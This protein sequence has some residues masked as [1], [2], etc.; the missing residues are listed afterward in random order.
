MTR[1]AKTHAGRKLH[2]PNGIWTY[3]IG[4]GSVNIRDPNGF[5]TNVDISTL[6]GWSD[7]DIERGKWKGYFKIKPSQVKEYIEK[8]LTI[9][10]SS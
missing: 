3:V 9:K 10:M 7:N 4:K 2:L 5:R 8:N 1:T 6:T